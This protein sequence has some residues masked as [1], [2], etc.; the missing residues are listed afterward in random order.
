MGEAGL[1]ERVMRGVRPCLRA[2]RQGAHTMSRGMR[3][4]QS[5]SKQGV[6]PSQACRRAFRLARTASSSS[7]ND[8]A[9]ALVLMR[10]STAKKLGC[11]PIAKILGHA[12]HSQAPNLFTTAP[13]GALQKLFAKTGWSAG[14]ELYEGYRLLDHHRRI[15]GFAA[16]Q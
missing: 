16:L 6:S 11:T 5:R 10:E 4:S 2:G 8:G 1:V 7:I 15:I 14:D 9:A 12:R 3:R 13:I